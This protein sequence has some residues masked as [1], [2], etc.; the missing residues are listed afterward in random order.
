MRCRARSCNIV[1]AYLSYAAGSMS[2]Q[3][4]LAVAIICSLETPFRA[5]FMSEGGTSWSYYFHHWTLVE[6]FCIS[7]LLTLFR[8][9]SLVHH[10]PKEKKI[11]IIGPAMFGP[12]VG[13]NCF[14]L[15]ISR[16]KQREIKRTIISYT[17]NNEFRKAIIF[18]ENSRSDNY[19]FNIWLFG[20]HFSTVAAGAVI[21]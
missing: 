16:Q 10:R 6:G 11:Q 17:L 8:F 1:T 3:H 21:L 14:P 13:Y 15:I 7:Q 2:S 9:K 18:K 12:P 5:V 4:P 20:C 19:T